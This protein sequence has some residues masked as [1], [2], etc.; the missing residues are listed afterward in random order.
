MLM[1]D[2]KNFRK[3]WWHAVDSGLLIANPLGESELTGNGKKRENVFVKKG[4]PFRLRYGCLIHLEAN[5]G[6]FSPKQAY[7]EF[8]TVIRDLDSTPTDGEKV[9]KRSE[10]PT[11]PEGFNISV[12]AQEPRAYKPTAI[13]FDA[14]G[15]LVVGQGPQYPKNFETTPTDSVVLVLDSDADGVADTTKTF[16][17]GIQQRAG[18]RLGKVMISTSR[19]HR[20]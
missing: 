7:G 6:A 16:A 14:K 2:P 20:N 15:R 3:P 4:E 10:L 8:L 17:T 5:A 13:C 18:P 1:N 11:V 19:T 9:I 12:F